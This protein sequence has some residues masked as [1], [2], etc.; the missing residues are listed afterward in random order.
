MVMWHYS[1]T[2]LRV[3]SWY[4]NPDMKKDSMIHS[5]IMFT[6]FFMFIFIIKGT[7]LY[8]TRLQAI[9]DGAIFNWYSNNVQALTSKCVN[10]R[11]TSCLDKFYLCVVYPPTK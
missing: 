3:S 7:I 5:L 9:L 8:K 2:D 11:L 4:K 1:E 6:L 10:Y